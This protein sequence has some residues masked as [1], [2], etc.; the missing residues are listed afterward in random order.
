MKLRPDRQDVF[1]VYLGTGKRGVPG[2]SGVRVW[3]E[4]LG[5]VGLNALEKHF[6]TQA[7]SL[8]NK[9]LAVVIGRFWSG[10]GF[11]FGKGSNSTPYLATSSQRMARQL[12]HL[13]LRLGM[14]SRVTEKVFAYKEGR[15]GY[16]V[17]L[18]GRRSL[19]VFAAVIVPHLI[20]R[21]AQIQ[22]LNRFLELVRQWLPLKTGG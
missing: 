19:E 14:V 4:A 3:L 18:L 20:G 8:S 7:F 9:D 22:L 21:D 5:V 15:V 6:P 12:Q 1:D 16:T 17:H 2:R 13:L 11:V 10:D